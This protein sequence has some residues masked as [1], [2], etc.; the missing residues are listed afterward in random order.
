MDQQAAKD[1][2][3]NKLRKRHAKL[4]YDPETDTI[5]MIKKDLAENEEL[6][7]VVIDSYTF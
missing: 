5:M 1:S 4:K 6:K 3:H 7:R 2:L